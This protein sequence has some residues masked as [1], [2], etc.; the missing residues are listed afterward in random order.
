MMAK[1]VHDDITM[2]ATQFRTCFIHK[3]LIHVIVVNVK[4]CKYGRYTGTGRPIIG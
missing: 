4:M 3:A 2:Y 1:Q